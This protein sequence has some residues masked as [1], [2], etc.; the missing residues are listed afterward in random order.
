MSVYPLTG[1]KI[2]VFGLARSG[3]AAISWLQQQGAYPIGIDADTQKCQQAQ[4]LGAEIGHL[5]T[6]DW[7]N[8]DAILQSPG[9]PLT[10]SLTQLAFQHHIPILC[11]CEIFR[12]AYPYAT[13]IGITGTNGKSTTTALIGHILH[14]AGF[15]TVIGGNIGVP[16]LSLPDLGPKGIYVFELS[17]YQLEM[18]TSMSMDIVAWLNISED[19]LDRHGSM[20]KYVKAK[21]RIFSFASHPP[22]SV[23]GIDDMYSQQIYRNQFTRYP[24]RT[25]SVSLKDKP[26]NG[27]WVHQHKLYHVTKGQEHLIKDLEKLGVLQGHHN[28]Q[29]IAVAYGVCQ[30]LGI[31]SEEI[32][33]G[34]HSFPGLEH[35]QEVVTT[36]NNITFI[37]DSKATNADAAAKALGLYESVYWIAGG[38]PKRDGIHDLYPY[39]PH[40][41]HAFLFGQAQ[42][43]FEDT[44]KGKVDYSTYTTLEE[45]LKQ[46]YQQ[47]QRDSAPHKIILFSPACASFDQFQDFE[48][49]GRVFK[50]LVHQLKDAAC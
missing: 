27:L 29:N 35:R 23:I 3:L 36:F 14:Q 43:E 18:T 34:I 38:V 44:L 22:K 19:H 41:A 15:P 5:E 7:I 12:Y 32:L 4:D 8:I 9:I 47:A 16:V 10:H 1:K 45:A 13:Y 48:H 17:S 25:I 2:V 50:H 11:D 37:N 20:E 49:R 24:D 21:T 40:V 39:F 33:A 26:E 46:A 28:E 42:T 30:Q 6:L 31:S